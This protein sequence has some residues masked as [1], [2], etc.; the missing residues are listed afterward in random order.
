M[1]L[2]AHGQDQCRPALTSLME[3]WRDGGWDGGMGEKGMLSHEGIGEGAW[4]RMEGWGRVD[5]VWG[6]KG[7]EGEEWDR[8][9]EDGGYE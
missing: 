3:G 4:G 8:G 2:M 1:D 9:I 7:K 6:D 5:D